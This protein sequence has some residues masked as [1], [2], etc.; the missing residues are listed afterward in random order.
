VPNSTRRPRR[1]PAWRCV[2]RHGPAGC[3]AAASGRCRGRGACSSCAGWPQRERSPAPRSASTPRGSGA[4]PRTHSRSRSSPLARAGRGR[5]SSSVFGRRVPLLLVAWLRQLVLVE[6]SEFH[7]GL[8][9]VGTHFTRTSDRV[10]I[11]PLTAYVV[12]VTDRSVCDR[13][14]PCQQLSGTG[15]K[16]VHRNAN[17][18]TTTS[19]N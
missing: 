12:K 18:R 4:R 14:E 5:S 15:L 6:Q 13:S 10:R 3:S 11:S 7:W 19:P 2:R 8:L 1:G 9:S 16:T 17:R